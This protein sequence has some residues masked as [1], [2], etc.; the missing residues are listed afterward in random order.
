MDEARE[1]MVFP[2]V[3]RPVSH[4]AD[5]LIAWLV[6]CQI[7]SILNIVFSWLREIHLEHAIID[8]QVVN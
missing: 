7:R 8:Y 5:N 4:T 6:Q 3:K 2:C 1:Q